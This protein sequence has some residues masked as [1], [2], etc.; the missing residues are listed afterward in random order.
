MAKRPVTPGVTHFKRSVGRTAACPGTESYASADFSRNNPPVACTASLRLQQREL[1]VE[2]VPDTPD[3]FPPG[4]HDATARACA[5][6]PPLRPAQRA[7]GPGE[8]Q[9]EQVWRARLPDQLKLEGESGHQ[10]VGDG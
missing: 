1:T 5:S 6:G 2:M 10:R 8:K 3:R 7:P 9:G 4:T